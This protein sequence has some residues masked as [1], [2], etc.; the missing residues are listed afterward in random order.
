MDHLLTDHL[1]RHHGCPRLLGCK[2]LE[3]LHDK[4]LHIHQDLPVYFAGSALHLYVYQLDQLPESE[5]LRRFI[6]PRE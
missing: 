3:R 6:V 5:W 4:E 1:D 2:L